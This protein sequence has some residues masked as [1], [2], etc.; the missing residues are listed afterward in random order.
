MRTRLPSV[1]APSLVA[2]AALA[3]AACGSAGPA[4]TLPDEQPIT[5]NV[6]TALE[7]SFHGEVIAREGEQARAAIIKQL[8]YLNGILV[9]DV[10]GNGQAAMPTLA[11]LT[12]EPLAEGGQ[13]RVGYDAKVA[14]IWPKGEAVPETY[15]L[16]LPLDSTKLGAFNAKYDGR[17]GKN[18]YGQATFWHDFHPK[19]AG[20]VVDDGDVYRAAVTVRPHPQATRDVYPEYDQVWADGVLD[21]VAVYGIISSNT[22]SDEGAVGR[23]ILLDAVADSIDD[24]VRTEHEKIPGILQ[25]STVTGTITRDGKKLT[26]RATAILVQ[27]AASAGSAFNARFAEASERSDIAIY[28]G[29]S[30]LGKNIAN[31]ASHLGAEAGHY[32][33]VYLFGCQTFAYL[34]PEMHDKRI[35]LNGAETD[36]EG[37]RFLDIM[38][39]ALPAYG[40]QGRS[41]IAIFKAFLDPSKPRTMNDLMNGISPGHL[42]LVFGEHDNRF[43]P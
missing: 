22:P 24:A 21:L 26:V 19:A 5:S 28:D 17:C 42:T 15:D 1:L 3:T 37:T 31:F 14:V 27:E 8:Q 18:K 38:A 20:C 40:D 29:H 43:E 6:G 2:L 7:M 9:G 16:V 11:N 30:G 25:D 35:A 12:E 32:Q 33:F 4:D 41:N 13:K 10:D 36:P 23:E 39:T 34:G